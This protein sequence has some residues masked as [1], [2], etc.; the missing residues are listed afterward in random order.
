[1]TTKPCSDRPPILDQWCEQQVGDLGAV[2]VRVITIQPLA[3][4]SGLPLLPRPEPRWLTL[5]MPLHGRVV[6]SQ[7]GR[8]AILG[9]DDFVIHDAARPCRVRVTGKPEMIQA[10]VLQL[11]RVLLPVPADQLERMLAVPIP[12]GPGIGTLT[13]RFL[14]QLVCNAGGFRPAD[15]VRLATAVLDL[16]A[17]R[18]AHELAVDG[19][20]HDTPRRELLVR[21]H[22]FVEENLGDP[23]LSPPTVAAAHHISLRYLH[24][25]F[26][27]QG[28]TVAAWIRQRRLDGCR[29]SLADPALAGRAV[30]TIAAGHG[31]T[32]PAHFS[33]AFKAA[34]GM[35][36]GQYR[37][38][39]LGL[40]G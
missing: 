24:K 29:R 37:R 36:P 18:L 32:S 28:A 2:H 19:A 27:D 11:P 31:F 40:A 20:I 16:L 39:V 15:A 17:A 26:H 22:A 9:P 10:L 4:R 3:R 34:Y 14:Q 13:S 12:S 8:R 5:T 7:D 30:A 35:P 33:Q 21:V 1:M 6:L 25:L 23:R 38:W